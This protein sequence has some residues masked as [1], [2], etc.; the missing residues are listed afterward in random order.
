MYSYFINGDSPIPLDRLIKVANFLSISLGEVENNIVSYKQ[1][2]VPN[3]NSVFNPKLPI[4]DSPYLASLVSH[5]FFDGS[6]PRDG[7]GAY[8]NQKKESIMKL[9]IEQLKEVFGDVQ[10]KTVVDHRGVLK[11]RFPQLVGEICKNLYGVKTFHGDF[12]R[13]PK[14]LFKLPKDYRLAFLVSAIL[15]EG[16]IA[17]DGHIIFGINNKD[18]C[19][20]MRA[21]GKGLGLEISELKRKKETSFFYFHIKS[22]DKLLKMVE[23]L[24]KD[25]PLIT[26]DYKLHRLKKSLEIKAQKFKYTANFAIERM[27]KVLIELTP[28]GRTINYLANQLVMPPRTIR[29]YMYRL[30]KEGKIKRTKSGNEYIY[31]LKPNLVSKMI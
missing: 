18:L 24:E 8:Y 20:D 25:Y 19:N 22:L 6:L 21:L 2:L 16:S 26:L 17:Y 29:R 5:L 1:K 30:M 7:K 10:N 31:L 3:K 9:F 14:K 4:K 28:K 13:I 23:G 15:D 12:G 11:C 27:E